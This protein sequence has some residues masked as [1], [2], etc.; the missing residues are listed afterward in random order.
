M[1]GYRSAGIGVLG[2][3]L[4]MSAGGDARG[5]G[6]AIYEQSAAGLGVAYAGMAALAEDASTVFWNPA[7][8]VHLP[9]DTFTF[10]G[11]YII[12]SGKFRN[13]G[14]MTL[15]PNVGTFPTSGGTGGD[16]GTPAF[17][18]ATYLSH[19]LSDDVW[20]GL[21]INAPFGLVT[22]YDDDWVGRYHGIHSELLTV[23]LNP[24]LGFKVSDSFSI[25]V[26]VSF[27]YAYA[28]LTN[29]VDTGFLLQAPGTADSFIKVDGGGFGFGANVGFQWA[30]TD[31]SRIGVHYRSEITQ[32]L[33]GD[34]VL[35]VHPSIPGIGGGTF[36]GLANATATLPDTVSISGMYNVTPDVTLVAD[37]T[38]TQ[39]SDLPAIVIDVS[40]LPTGNGATVSQL[41][42]EDTWRFSAGAIWRYDDDLSFRVGYAFDES[43]VP[44]ATFRTP[45]I[46]D[47][48]RHWLG[49]GVNY[50]I[51]DGVEAALAYGHHFVPSNPIANT[52]PDGL[53][54]LVGEFD[55]QTNLFTF[56]LTVD[57]AQLD[58]LMP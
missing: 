19:Q 38:W 50:K 24:S 41:N 58:T 53:H 6:F 40:G 36:K 57:L 11:S 18:G 56:G 48:D 55:S 32:S 43:P 28:S 46:P 42:W 34:A 29:A 47:A 10:V 8:M 13:Q 9:G 25:G 3:G 31:D 15:V 54:T 4:A 37:A 7:G 17:V 33:S 20:F 49:V 35:S 52:S 51:L 12:P 27:Q 16:A 39:W 1:K 26:G 44:S 30:P 5:A 22:D 14:S 45:R 2:L 23:N 21:G